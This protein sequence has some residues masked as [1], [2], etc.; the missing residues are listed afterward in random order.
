MPLDLIGQHAE[1]DVRTDS[2]LKSMVDGAD[3]QVERFHGAECPLDF[4]ERL[5]A[6]H[7]LGGVHLFFGHTGADDVDA[8]E[9]RF[10]GNL[11]GESMEREA[12]LFDGNGEEL[13]HLVLVHH[14]TDT[15]SDP[16]LTVE[17]SILDAEADLFQFPLGRRQ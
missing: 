11:L 4:R 1:Q 7:R 12:A 17:R 5:V 3:M 15:D 10:G 9:S 16:V 8:I 14:R 6:A 13:G 2:G